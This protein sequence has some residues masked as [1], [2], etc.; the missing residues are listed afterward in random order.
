MKYKITSSDIYD[1][2][3]K[4]GALILGKNRLD[5]Y[6]NKFLT[7][8]C[9]QALIEPMPIPVEKILEDM[10][11]T[12]HETSL[13]KD[14]DVFGCCLILDGRID[15]YN[16]ETGLYIST[17]FNAG[18]VL[19]DPLSEAVYG[20]GSKRNTLVHEALHWE[21][22]K[23]YFEILQL[24]NKDASEKLFPILCRQS[25][26]FFT[27]SEGK[28]TKENEVRWLEWQA[29]RLAPRILMPKDNFKK[30][31]IE[32]IKQINE[33]NNRIKSCDNLVEYLSKFFIVSRLSVK[34]RLI[35]VGLKE[36]ISKFEDFNDIYEEINSNNDFVKLTPFEAIQ[37]S[38]E[39]STLKNWIK[40]RRFVFVDGYFVL[41]DSKY[42]LQENGSLHLTPKA[43]KNLSKCVLNIREQ[44]Y[45]TYTN[46]NKDYLGFAFLTKVEGVDKRLLTFHPKYQ[47]NFEYEAA[48]VYN[49]FINNVTSYD[50]QE[51]I[52]LI[53]MIGDPTKTLCD[54]LWFLMEN[55]GWKYPRIF[56]EKTELHNNYYGKIKNNRYNN[57]MTGVLM[58]ICVGLKL[59]LR[60][61]EKLFEKSKNKLNYYEN[62][63]KIYIHIMET[64]P[65]L[66]ISDF[67]GILKQYNIQELGTEIIE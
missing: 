53:K 37:I 44:R 19:I 55:R 15:V 64:M 13:S 23:V 12:V 67:N 35:E 47:T 65:G 40:E 29:H 21:K 14:L 52:E 38:L 56:N 34:Y 62:P 27:P 54:C 4:S 31:A 59:S 42:I 24:K 33:S 58:A 16:Q 32:Y 11:L 66:P 6:A 28:N 8:Y 20:E 18:T 36:V 60:L 48:D 50:E 41:A 51:E 9:K 49:S 30:K 43:K 17:E 22:D 25:E 26:T 39:D 7:K 10:G 1:T 5:D 3:R 45:V 57:M 63:D 2:N 61:T 46:R